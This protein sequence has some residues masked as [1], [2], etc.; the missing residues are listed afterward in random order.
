MLLGIEI[1]QRPLE[2]E[3]PVTVAGEEHHETVI[4]HEDIAVV[5]HIQVG[6]HE[7]GAF[8]RLPDVAHGDLPGVPVHLHLGFV[9]LPEGGGQHLFRLVERSGSE[10]FRFH[11]PVGILRD[12]NVLHIGIL[13]REVI[14]TALEVLCPEARRSQQQQ[15]GQ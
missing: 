4:P 12:E 13:V 7:T 1:I 14:G 11:R 2:R 3:K 10:R 8:L 5:G 6:T 15:A 9:T